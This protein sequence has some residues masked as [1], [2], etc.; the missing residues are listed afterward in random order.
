MELSSGVM[1]QGE[2]S[3]AACGVRTWRQEAPNEYEFAL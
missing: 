2:S 1:R 3:R